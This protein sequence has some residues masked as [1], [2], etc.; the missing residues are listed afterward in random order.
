M[1]FITLGWIFQLETA[2]KYLDYHRDQF[3]FKKSNVKFVK[4]YIED[5]KEAGIADAS[6]DIIMWDD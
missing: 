5:L 1:F 2:K 6:T 3:G 4:G